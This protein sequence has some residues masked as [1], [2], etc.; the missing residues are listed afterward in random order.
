MIFVFTAVVFLFY[1]CIVERRQKKVYGAAQKSTAIVSSLF[2]S[3]VRDRLFDDEK[4]AKVS[5]KGAFLTNQVPSAMVKNGEDG[6]R[7]PSSG[8]IKN[9]GPAIADLFPEAVSLCWGSGLSHI[10]SS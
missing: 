4:Q 5:K 6:T 3:N 8:R 2:P 1:D 7:T 10:R 9:K